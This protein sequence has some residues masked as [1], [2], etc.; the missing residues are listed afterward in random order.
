M[1][2]QKKEDNKGKIKDESLTKRKRLEYYMGLS[3][4]TVLGCNKFN[5]E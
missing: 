3:F 4:S 2:K 1:E 5:K